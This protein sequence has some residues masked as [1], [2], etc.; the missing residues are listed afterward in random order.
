MRVVRSSAPTHSLTAKP[1]IT[2]VHFRVTA[3]GECVCARACGRRCRKRPHAQLAAASPRQARASA[4][5][6]HVRCRSS[7]CAAELHWCVPLRCGAAR[8]ERARR[9]LEHRQQS[10]CRALD[11]RGREYYVVCACLCMRVAWGV[12]G[13]EREWIEADGKM[14]AGEAVRA[15]RST[16]R[17]GVQAGQPHARVRPCSRAGRSG[18]RTP[19]RLRARGAA[20]A[21]AAW[22]ATA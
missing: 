10:L 20:C 1:S 22:Q 9:E 15:H 12:Q 13:R 14:V 11:G 7:S 21:S 4:V 5:T 2:P 17:T 19:R 8:G 6:G 3:A 16:H 18:H